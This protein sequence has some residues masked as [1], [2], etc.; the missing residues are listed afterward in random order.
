MVSISDEIGDGSSLESLNK[1]VSDTGIHVIFDHLISTKF[2]RIPVGQAVQT[3]TSNS[4]KP[5]A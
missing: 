5:N 4:G 2:F 1:C 3:S